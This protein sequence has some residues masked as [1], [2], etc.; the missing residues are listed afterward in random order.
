MGF[1]GVVAPHRGSAGPVVHHRG[2]HLL[3]EGVH[4]IHTALVEGLRRV[5]FAA[6]AVAAAEVAEEAAGEE[7][8]H[9]QHKD[10][11]AAE[12]GPKLPY[13]DQRVEPPQEELPMG[14]HTDRHLPV[15]VLG[16]LHTRERR[17]DRFLGRQ[18]VGLLEEVGHQNPQKMQNSI[19][20]VVALQSHHQQEEVA[21][22]ILVG[23]QVP[24]KDCWHPLLVVQGVGLEGLQMD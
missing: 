9:R 14:R 6:G 3:E 13:L 17:R 19:F 1:A 11:I 23:G 5:P 22:H 2:W 4:R 8:L 16:G 10:S 24:Q 12:Q 7:A 18:E 21:H 15:V 20:E